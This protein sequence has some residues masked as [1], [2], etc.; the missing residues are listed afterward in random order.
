MSGI[1][2]PKSSV[3]EKLA[4]IFYTIREDFPG[5]GAL[6][7]SVIE[8]L[9]DEELL[10]WYQ[11]MA[12]LKF[13]PFLPAPSYIVDDSLPV[14]DLLPPDLFETPQRPALNIKLPGTYQPEW[15]PFNLTPQQI[16]DAICTTGRRG[17]QVFALPKPTHPEDGGF[18][19]AHASYYEAESVE[20][21]LHKCLGQ[22]P[23]EEGF[24]GHGVKDIE[25]QKETLLSDVVWEKGSVGA[26]DSI[27]PIPEIPV[28]D[29]GT[30]PRNDF[31]GESGP[32]ALP[33]EPAQPDEPPP[34]SLDF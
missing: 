1:L 4:R 23:I 31:S 34:L 3:L 32:E 14:P 12:E 9:N 7:D 16:N 18:V 28:S 22:F 6:P 20:G 21:A 17:Y 5:N 29:A 19:V 25:T 2:C 24:T 27:T 33:L 30:P 15:S 10:T 13:V 11:G 26:L 8:L